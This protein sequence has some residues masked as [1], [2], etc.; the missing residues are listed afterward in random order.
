MKN[1][2][3]WLLIAATIYLS[4]CAKNYNCVCTNPGGSEVVF[5][6][7]SSKTKAEKKCKE[8]YDSNYGNIPW[9]ETNCSIE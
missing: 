7:R 6:N 9:N 8:Y 1:S 3:I 2:T 5:I 4:S